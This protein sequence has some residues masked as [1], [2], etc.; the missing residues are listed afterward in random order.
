MQSIK[1]IF[2]RKFDIFFY[3][4]TLS[5]SSMEIIK[6]K[7]SSGKIGWKCRIYLPSVY[8]NDFLEIVPL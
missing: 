1:K 5:Y 7:N 4:I 6:L 3:R 8:L 2:L